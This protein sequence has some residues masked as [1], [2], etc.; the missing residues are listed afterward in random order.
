MPVRAFNDL[1]ELA[2]AVRELP[3]GGLLPARTV[4][5]RSER[6]AHALRALLSAGSVGA[7]A[8]TRFVGPLSAAEE[9]L[10]AAGVAFTE[11]EAGL[12]PAR[13]AALFRS[14][15]ALEHFAADLLTT[16]PGWAEAFAS[17]IHTLEGAGLRPGDLPR[18]HAQLRDLAALWARADEEA[19][20]SFTAA[21]IYAEAA[22]VLAR[23]PRVWP[24]PGPVLAPV[25]GHE[26]GALARFLRAVPAST[27]ALRDARP[28]PARWLERLRLLYGEDA[29]AAL[30]ARREAARGGAPATELERLQALLFDPAPGAG[31]ASMGPG[32]GPDGTVELEEHAGVE[33]ELDAT[34]AWV[35]RKVLEDRLPLAR[36]AVLVPV[37]D[38]LAQLVADRVARLG[39][40]VHVAGAVPASA[41]SAGA[42]VLAVL[43]AL[44]RRL[45]AEALAA[46]LPFLRIEAE[47]A[48]GGG[49]ARTHLSHGDALDLAF[50]L[51][52]P[53]GSP[54]RPEGA[55]AWSR[56]AAERVG[57]LE[58]AI[59]TARAGGGSDEREIFRLERTLRDLRAVRGSLDALVEVARAVHEGRA[60]ELLW[61]ALETFLRDAVL[62]PGGAPRLLGPLGEALAPAR[63]SPA[64]GSLRG[65]D[66]LDSVRAALGSLRLGRGRFGEPA[67]YVGTVASAAGLPFDAV[68]I[69]GLAEG[70]IP[71]APREDPVL[72]GFLREALEAGGAGLLPSPEDRVC[73]QLQALH[74]VIRGARRALALSAPRVDL[75]RTEREPAALLIEVAAALGRPDRRTGEEAAPVPDAQALRRDAFEPAREA[76]LAFRRDHP[77]SEP[78]WLARAAHG[79][80]DLPPAWRGEAALD[81]VRLATLRPPGRLGA[82]DGLLAPGDPFPTVPGLDPARPISASALGDLLACPRRF[83]MA[84]LLRWDA[85]A[86]APPLRELGAAAFGSLL[87]RVLEQLYRAHGAEIVGRRKALAHWIALGLEVADAVFAESLLAAPLL[88]ARIQ[89]KE[90]ARL[91][92]AVRAFVEYD[93]AAEEGRRFVDVERGFGTRDAPLALPVPGGALHVRGFM[94]RLDATADRTIVRD[95]KSGRAH[96]R[97]GDEAGPV[98]GRDV[99]LGL[100]VKVARA[101]AEAWGVPGQAVGA[102]AYA[103][104]KG[105]VRERAFRA[106]VGLLED[107]T[108]RW[109]GLARG[110]LADHA[111][112]GTPDEGD[113]GYCPF[114]PLCG[115][116]EPARA[117][118][119]LEAEADGTLRAFLALKQGEEP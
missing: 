22:A 6:Q 81:L 36:V 82:A 99:Q 78:D 68:R 11:G 107:A 110:L 52:T 60:L 38:P 91:H 66:A 86:A 84:R 89:E 31:A 19:G 64:G 73:A 65:D 42:R 28:A 30:R 98:A 26:G 46:V 47:P 93:W 9:V 62:L 41:T 50:S 102:Y 4:L 57:E 118:L 83:L 35:A 59:A 79:A 92:Q 29:G 108:E 95:V 103:S 39:V 18:S 112:P 80:P 96:L 1:E 88:G 21:R 10:Q 23:D 37:Q 12:R 97:S 20:R 113:C 48:E 85:P 40:A 45:P 115:S 74:A 72:P 76:A 101:L 43:R 27:L 70:S 90:R 87:H 104:G 24:F 17:A 34:A 56:R 94:D 69:V 63:G 49:F 75:A 16:R 5:V 13:L 33:S 105:E 116:E 61:A 106:D 67:V 2:R 111:F 15:I 8:G 77:V 100:Y 117:A 7:L 119:G 55:L 25:D 53:G 54:A 51:G 44:R 14:G 58:R 71:S 32:R 114:A 3:A 109:L